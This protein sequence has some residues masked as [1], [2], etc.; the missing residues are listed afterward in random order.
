MSGPVHEHID[1]ALI[2]Q[3]QIFRVVDNGEGNDA[4]PDM[5]SNLT[6]VDPL[7]RTELRE[8][9]T[10][11]DV[12]GPERQRAGEAMIDSRVYDARRD[13]PLPSR[14]TMKRSS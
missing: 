9:H 2:G 13:K 6:F 12:R 7:D 4:P 10:D 11:R 8:L 14:S 5:V 3:T 1:P